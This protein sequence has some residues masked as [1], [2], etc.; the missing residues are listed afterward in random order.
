MTQTGTTHLTETRQWW[1]SRRMLYN[2]GLVIAG[3][4]AFVCYV[5]VVSSD[6][7]MQAHPEAEI[8]VFTTLFQG[9]GYLFMMAI[10]NLCYLLGP[11]SE[12][13]IRPASVN[14]Y[15]KVMFGLG[16]WFSVLLPFCIPALLV[17]S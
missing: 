15:R 7:F 11:A 3:V 5:G 1:E 8:T 6:R 10:A 16:F 12:H 9:V 2:K 4:L 17:W 14:T 13:L